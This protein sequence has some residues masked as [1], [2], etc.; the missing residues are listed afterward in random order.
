MLKT[1]TKAETPKPSA[2]QVLDR[3]KGIIDKHAYLKVDGEGVYRGEIYADYRDNL[4]NPMI[5]KI[6]EASNANE[7]FFELINEGFFDVES[8][9][10]DDVINTIKKHFDDGETFKFRQHKN[11]ITEW[12]YEN[13]YFTYPYDHYLSQNVCV[14]VLVDV[15]D[16]NYDYTLNELFGCN[17][18]KKGLDGRDESSLV[19]LMKQQGYTMEAITDFVE[20]GN[21]QGSKFLESVYQECANTNSCMN[22]LAFFVNIPLRQALDLHSK[23]NVTQSKKDGDKPNDSSNL[24]VI[25]DEVILSKKTSC[26][27]YNPWQGSGSVLEIELEKDVVL[28]LRYI[29]SA[30]PDGCRG[31]SVDGIYGL[32]SSFWTDN[33]L[34]IKE[35]GG[36]A[37]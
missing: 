35:N 9:Y 26:G 6:F 25:C 34:T 27:L 7:A 37:A 23:I 31:Y 2:E 13:V 33:G 21:T 17:Y 3:V 4:D 36:E 11:R 29:D 1:K 18:S 16:G 8:Q 22:V 19:W 12:V 5:E 14:N 20:S 28:P 32:V 24:G 10:Q 15:G 30:M